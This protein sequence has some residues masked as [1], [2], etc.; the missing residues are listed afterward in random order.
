MLE[1]KLWYAQDD[2]GKLEVGRSPSLPEWWWLYIMH[3]GMASADNQ[4]V[5]L[6]TSS[7]ARRESRILFTVMIVQPVQYLEHEH[8]LDIV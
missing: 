8:G 6:S 3:N 4:R 7:D 1:E 2:R 5:S